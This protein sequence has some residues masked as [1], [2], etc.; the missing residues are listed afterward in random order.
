MM[1]ST[2]SLIMFKGA[3]NI[4][5]LSLIAANCADNIVIYKTCYDQYAHRAFLLPPFFEFHRG[6]KHDNRMLFAYV[7]EDAIQFFSSCF[8]WKRWRSKLDTNVFPC[9]PFLIGTLNLFTYVFP[10][11]SVTKN[12]LEA[13]LD[14]EITL[15]VQ[16][17]T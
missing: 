14:I 6:A 17:E 4:W 11:S 3:S 15:R 12:T 5:Q 16:I 7:L 9:L 2:V 13:I 1:F 10:V 8:V